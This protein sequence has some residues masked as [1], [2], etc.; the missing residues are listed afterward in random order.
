[1]LFEPSKKVICSLG[2]VSNG[3]KQRQQGQSKQYLIPSIFR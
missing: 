3:Q 2:I 1:L